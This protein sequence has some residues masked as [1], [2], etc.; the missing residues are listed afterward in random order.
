[1][2]ER[3]GV[4]A[5]ASR[6][7]CQRRCH[8]QP[9]VPIWRNRGPG[10]ING[11]GFCVDLSKEVEDDQVAALVCL[12]AQINAANRLG[13]IVRKRGGSYV[14]GM[15]TRPRELNE[16]ATHGRSNLAPAPCRLLQVRAQLRHEHHGHAA[17]RSY[18]GSS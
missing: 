18:A 15:F 10:Q 9:K 16:R 4:V 7:A 11:C 1:V 2:L 12:I 3:S 17:P 8:S 14:P 13:V 5:S 6:E